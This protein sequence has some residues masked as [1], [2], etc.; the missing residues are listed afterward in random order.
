MPG[1]DKK[2]KL[3]FSTGL[4]EVLSQ[5]TFLLVLPRRYRG[6]VSKSGLII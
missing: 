4:V 5:Q 3:K 2:K 6:L 1:N